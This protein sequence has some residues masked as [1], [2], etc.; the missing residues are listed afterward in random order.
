MYASFNWSGIGAV[1][2][3]CGEERLVHRCWTSRCSHSPVI[4]TLS[5]WDISFNGSE[6]MTEHSLCVCVCVC[7]CVLQMVYSWAYFIRK[8]HDP[9]NYA[10]R[11]WT[12]F[13]T[14]RNWRWQRGT[15]ARASVTNFLNL[16]FTISKYTLLVCRRHPPPTPIRSTKAHTHTRE[17]CQKKFQLKLS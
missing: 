15:A 14:C 9:V 12:E 10:H 8:S 7:V 2:V 1:G 3:R 4:Y 11:H 13:L 5:G 17:S 6:T 16:S